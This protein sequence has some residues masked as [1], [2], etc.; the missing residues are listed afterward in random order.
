MLLFA[1]TMEALLKQQKAEISK[2]LN[3]ISNYGKAGK[4]RKTRKYLEDKRKQID[5]LWKELDQRNEELIPFS[6]Q[7][8][9][10]FKNETFSEAK[11]LYEKALGNIKHRLKEMDG[12]LTDDESDNLDDSVFVDCTLT[13]IEPYESLESDD[14]QKQTE[15]DTGA[16]NKNGAANTQ[17]GTST[18]DNT[19]GTS[20]HP[21]NPMLMLFYDEIMDLIIGGQRMDDDASTGQISIHLELINSAW[22]HLKNYVYEHKAKGG[23]VE[24]NLLAVM[25]RY[26]KV[27]GY[28][29][30]LIHDKKE[31]SG[32]ASDAQSKLPVIKLHEFSGKITE[33]KSFIAK[34][35]RLVHNNKKIDNGIKIEYLKMSIKG[36]AAKL[37][38]HIDP[39]P[40]NY[41]NCYSILKKRYDNKREITNCLIEN[42]MKFPKIRAESSEQLKSLHDTVYESIMTIKSIGVSVENWDPLLTFILTTKLDQA[43]IINYECQLKDVREPQKLVDMLTYIENRF[44]ALNS[45]GYKS[46]TFFQQK[47]NNRSFEKETK[48]SAINCLY[49]ADTHSTFACTAFEKLPT[50]ERLDW[51]RS[52][53]KCVNCFG[54]H[55]AQECKSKFR[56]KHCNG[57]HNTLLHLDSKPNAQKYPNNAQKYPNNAK[58]NKHESNVS[59]SATVQLQST[60]VAHTATVLLATALIGAYAKDGTKIML[61]A[62]LDQGSQSAFITESAAQTLKLPRKETNATII[63]IGAKAQTAKSAVEMS[64]FP[65]FESDFIMNVNAIVLPKLTKVSS[66]SASEADYDFVNDL[67]L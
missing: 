19:G 27:S 55:K 20:N 34:F 11:K 2:L 62:L 51:V 39:N 28:L 41:E 65:R 18:G 40:D 61:R 29:S 59:N 4:P 37:I 12:D 24:F 44:M 26:I 35:D 25:D 58:I 15:S 67:T 8:Q 10:Y 60:V 5:A 52:E 38:N 53:K 45:A 1:F 66:I 46:D 43:T 14:D 23:T 13:D 30:D 54:Q 33:W 64:I 21:Q 6:T 9:D 3:V 50:Q 31:S 7:S 16:L 47:N 57:K 32:H 17:E 56:C 63:G 42:I 49:C 36:D 48:S 22:K